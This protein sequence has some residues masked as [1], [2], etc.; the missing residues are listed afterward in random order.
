MTWPSV[1]AY[2]VYR[3]APPLRRAGLR[4]F[5]RIKFQPY[6]IGRAFNEFQPV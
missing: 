3:P 1:C 2:A 6:L 5:E 4:L